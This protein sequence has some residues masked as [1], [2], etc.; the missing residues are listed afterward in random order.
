MQSKSKIG[1]GDIF[2]VNPLHTPWLDI[3]RLTPAER[4]KLHKPD[5]MFCMG[6]FLS[7]FIVVGATV[8]L[9]TV[10]QVYSQFQLQFNSDTTRGE[11]VS[12]YIDVDDDDTDYYVLYT[13]VVNDKRYEGKDSVSEEFYYRADNGEPYRVTY[14]KA[15]PNIA[16]LDGTNWGFAIFMTVFTLCWNGFVWAI[17][18]GG[19]HSNNL[20][21]QLAKDGFLIN[22]KITQLSAKTD[23]DGDYGIDIHY[24][25]MSPKTGQMIDSK[26]W[27]SRSDLKSETLPD[28]PLNIKIVYLTDKNYKLI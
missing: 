21:K 26:T 4:K 1:Y 2:I 13:Y 27:Q 12:H 18:L 14:A 28:P 20:A 22:G 5:G 9:A 15:D 19:I 17:V 23:S 7:L 3:D 25:F 8:L 10:Y 24:R 11:Y 6:I 16:S